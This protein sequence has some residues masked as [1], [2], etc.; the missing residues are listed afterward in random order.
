M[1][2]VLVDGG[3]YCAAD[4]GLTEQIVPRVLCEAQPEVGLNLHSVAWLPCGRPL[5]TG[6]LIVN[7]SYRVLGLEVSI[8]GLDRSIT[9]LHGYPAA[10]PWTQQ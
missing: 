5:D 10:N 8:K 6:T 1:V 4:G 9:A 3:R 7:I 2:V